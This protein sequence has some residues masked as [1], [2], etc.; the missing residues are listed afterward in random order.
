MELLTSI[1]SFS[2][3]ASRTS[4]A[5]MRTYYLGTQRKTSLTCCF[6]PTSRSMLTQRNRCSRSLVFWT[7][8]SLRSLRKTK[9]K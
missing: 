6:S 7:T 5:T 4:A 9:Q 8:Y 1:L 3:R 2:L